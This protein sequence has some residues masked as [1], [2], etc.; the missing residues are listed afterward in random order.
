MT[1][2][3]KPLGQAYAP[4][5][6]GAAIYTVPSSTMAIV[7]EIRVVNTDS[8][9]RDVTIFAN[10]TTGDKQIVGLRTLQPNETMTETCFITLAAGGSIQ[11]L[12]S[13]ASK[14]AVSVWGAETS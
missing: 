2:V 9:P 11:S 12:G 7:R 13:L 8:A 14:L 1:D 3:F 4:A 5:S 10:G 6:T